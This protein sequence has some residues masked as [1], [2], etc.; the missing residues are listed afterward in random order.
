[1]VEIYYWYLFL[2][3]LVYDGNAI[4]VF[5]RVC[6]ATD[7]GHGTSGQAVFS[8]AFRYVQIHIG[9]VGYVDRD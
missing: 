7:V 4:D 3:D 6:N 5:G 8:T 1:M 9:R 2:H